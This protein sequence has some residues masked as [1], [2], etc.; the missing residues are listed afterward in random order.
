MKKRSLTLRLLK[1]LYPYRYFIVLALSLMIFAKGIEAYIPLYIG[2]VSEELF[3][4]SPL[5]YI[6]RHC[7]IIL[8]LLIFTYLLDAVNV[9]LKNWIGQKGLY[10]LRVEVFEHIQKMPLDFFS[11]NAVGT[12][13]TRTIHDV[14]QI[15]Q[16]FADSL[17]PLFGSLVLFISVAIVIG[18]HDTR[19]AFAL[20]VTLPIVFVLTNFFRVNQRR[21][22]DKIRSI[23]SKLN[24]FVQ[25][26]LM[27]VTLVRRF[28]QQ[29]KEKERFDKI[30]RDLKGAN[31]E[32]IHYFAQ[33]FAGIDFMQS[34]S[35]ILVFVVL[36]AFKTK[37]E[38]FEAGVYFAYSLYALMLFRPLAD[39]AERYNLLQAAFASAKRIFQIMDMQPEP[40]GE[41]S[42]LKIDEI[43]SIDFEDVWFAYKGQEW[44]LKGFNL[45]IKKGETLAIVGITGAG[46]TTVMNLLLRFYECQK[47][48]ILI[49]GKD[50]KEYSIS[51]VRSHFSICLQDAEIFSGTIADNISLFDPK[52]SKKEILDI[53]DYVGLRSLINKFPD[54]IDFRL[55]ERGKTLSQ[56]EKQL[57]SIARAMAYS[58]DILFFDEATANIDSKTEKIIQKALEK[59]LHE[60]TA[61][62]IAHRLST[63]KDVK[64]IVVLHNG[65]AIE[66]G[67][68]LE[69]LQKRGIYEKLYRLQF[70]D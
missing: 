21:C 41:K 24:A 40:G 22:Y 35:L 26:G 43:K 23:V 12:L 67:S 63:I 10:T 6:M 28:G 19:L 52:I 18:F 46:K 70:V 11:K 25:E 8:G 3:N 45:S 54:G 34:F 56:G 48:K 4:Q 58:R 7:F 59:I 61:I 47:G 17:V 64:K 53:I 27:G 51:E 14:D 55:A 66:E 38:Q 50:I 15:N 57:I 29:K 60:K 1:Y 39:L 42:T 2:F 36:V 33:F 30:N 44:V 9:V 20:F 49:N 62:V 5:N 65:V 32:T 13:M 37:G 69:L 68:H 31:V 16:M